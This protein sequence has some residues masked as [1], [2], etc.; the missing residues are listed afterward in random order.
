LLKDLPPEQLVAAVVAAAV[1]DTL[2]APAVT[3]RLIEHVT[4]TSRPPHPPAA[5]SRLTPREVEVLQLLA[6]GLSNAEIDS[7]L[8]VAETTVKTHIA[9]VLTKLGLRDRVQA[10]VFAYQHGLAQPFPPG[11]QSD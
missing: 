3:R 5:I 6:Q 2:L 9:R 1:G 11:P 10:V 4:A 8:F 7:Q